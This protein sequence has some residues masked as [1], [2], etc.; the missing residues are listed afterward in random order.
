MRDMLQTCDD[1][2]GLES[3]SSASLGM[4]AKANTGTARIVR[5]EGRN[6]PKT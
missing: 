4:L 2:R 5:K 1:E 3:S 6:N